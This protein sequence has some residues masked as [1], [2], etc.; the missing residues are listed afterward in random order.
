M[1]LSLSW[2]LLAL[3]VFSPAKG[4]DRI[5][6]GVAYGPHPRQRLDIYAPAKRSRAAPTLVFFYGGAWEFGRRAEYAFAARAFA[7]HGFVTVLPDYRLVPEVKFP[8]FV[9]DCADA[10]AWAV[11]NVAFYG[12]DPRRI[13]LTGHS[14]GAYNAMM[15]VLDRR[16]LDHAGLADESVKAVVGLAG[17]YDFLP[18]DA[19]TSRTAFCHPQDLART[20]PVSFARADVPP[21]LLLQGLRDEIVVPQNVHSLSAALK[22]A[23]AS[24]VETKFYDRADHAALLLGLS[25]WFRRRATV[26]AD[27]VEFLHRVLAV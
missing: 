14:A 20:Q 27:S 7:A 9:E 22:R 1:G 11:E 13:A 18:E 3:N 6:E 4:V 26:L 15:M 8:A 10:V 23:G 16:F 17:P 12:G 5:A 21:M 25:P 2:P 24:I 19:A